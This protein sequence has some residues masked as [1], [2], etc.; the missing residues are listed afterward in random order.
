MK[1][2][3]TVSVQTMRL[4]ANYGNRIS[5]TDY[6]VLEQVYNEQPVL[7]LDNGLV[8]VSLSV[9][10]SDVETANAFIEMFPKYCNLKVRQLG[11]EYRYSVVFPLGH[12]ITDSNVAGALN[13]TAI[14][15]VN[16]QMEI[17]GI[18]FN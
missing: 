9:G 4:L 1:N 2:E 12:D 17:L 5:N 10:F 14:K 18:I 15:R 13:E 8:L 7:K 3:T 6:R 16:K 11:G